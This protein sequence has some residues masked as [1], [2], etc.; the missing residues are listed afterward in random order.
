M[1]GFL[2]IVVLGI[3]IDLE[4]VVSEEILESLDEITN[5]GSNSHLKFKEGSG[6]LTPFSILEFFHLGLKLHISLGVGSDTKGNGKSGKEKECCVF[7]F[8]I[9]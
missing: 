1:L 6:Y 8:W 3:D 5:W 2:P 9:I 4:L 7:H